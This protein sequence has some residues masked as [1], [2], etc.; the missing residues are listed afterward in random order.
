MTSEISTTR[1]ATLL[2]GV[3]N[4]MFR[5][6]FQKSNLFIFMGVHVQSR[7]RQGSV[8]SSKVNQGFK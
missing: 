4:Q 3:N 8:D 5:S 1:L 2:E 6:E 7:C